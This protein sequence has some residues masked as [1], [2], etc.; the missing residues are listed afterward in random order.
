MTDSSI[1]NRPQG[2]ELQ[3]NLVAAPGTDH[4]KPA[5]RWRYTLALSLS[6]LGVVFGDIGTSPLY[7]LRECFH[8]EHAVPVTPGNVFGVLSL[9]FW[10]MMIVVTI[11]YLIFVLRADNRGEGGIL[12]LTALATPIKVI[13]HTERWWLVIL[14]IFGAALLY[15][16]GMITPAISVLSAVEGLN[17]AT[18]VFHPFII[19]ITLAILVGL[20]LLQSHGTGGIGKLFGPVMAVW[21]IAIALLGL[22]GMLRDPRVLAAWNPL[23]GLRFFVENGWRGVLVLGS[24]FL[25]VTGG[26]A[27]YA[28]MG[29]FGRKPIRI[30]WF[31][32]AWPALM[33]NYLGQ[34]ALLLADPQAAA[35]PFYLLSPGW[36]L[37]PLVALAT[38]AAVIASQALISGA[39]SITMQATQLGLL[40]RLQIKHTSAMEYGQIYLPT[41]NWLLM[42]GCLLIVIGFRTSNALA[43]AY[44]IA[45]TSTMAITT[46]IFY[47]VARERWKWSRLHSA[48]S[49]GAFLIV[50]VAFLVANLVKIRDGGWF[51]I[52]IAVAIFTL[53]TTWKRGRRILARRML[54]R[55]YPFADFLRDI[56]QAPPLRVPGTAVFM[57]GS[58]DGVPPAL[59]QNLLHNRVLHESILL[60]TVK[61]QQR[62]HVPEAERVETQSLGHRFFRVT[63]NVGF[64]DEPDV[65]HALSL[66]NHA[67]LQ[68][69]PAKIS[70]FLGRE[71]LLACAANGGMALWRERLFAMM[72]QN[73]TSPTSFFNLPPDRVVELGSH[74]EI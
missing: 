35:N 72:S 70:Y 25:A 41:V 32:L 62:P 6:A 15:G 59:L 26:E 52:V 28:D 27:L 51:P 20:F 66:V 24:V 40:P 49:A 73:A 63:I 60:L 69:E 56:E 17:V 2:A 42:V 68:L 31:T 43:A 38:L 7:A 22:F 45:V 39:F 74:I 29:H 71:T 46:I 18:N 64:M 36:L 8:G 12:A 48:L 47:V 34:G 37:Y 30:A 54:E 21:F 33:L 1:A 67:E 11:K 4:F 58:G 50:D 65:P 13:S 14:G 16:D 57:S 5:P 53:M 9:V 19:P 23:Y 55:A 44:G 10:A 61:T 3:I